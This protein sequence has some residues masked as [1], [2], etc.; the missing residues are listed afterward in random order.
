ML[1]ICK[2]T[3]KYKYAFNL[4]A[5][6]HYLFTERMRMQLLWSRI[7]NVYGKRGHNV[8]MD[9][10]MEHLNRQCKGAYRTSTSVRML[11]L[12]LITIHYY[13]YYC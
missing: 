6:Y 1:V 11:E 13:Y 8:A 3:G 7:V 2:V 12:Q 5:Q 9:L 4:L 10:H